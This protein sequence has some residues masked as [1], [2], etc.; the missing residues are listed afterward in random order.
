M[1]K[2]T[3]KLNQVSSVVSPS[4]SNDVKKKKLETVNNAT[5]NIVS[6]CTKNVSRKIVNSYKENAIPSTDGMKLGEYSFSL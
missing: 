5:K 2:S 6:I 4:N 1:H 3:F